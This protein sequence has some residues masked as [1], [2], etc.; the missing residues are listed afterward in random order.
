[1]ARLFFL[2]TTLAGMALSKDVKFTSGGATGCISLAHIQALSH[3]YNWLNV[4]T[5]DVTLP[6]IPQQFIDDPSE[7]IPESLYDLYFEPI[8]EISKK[9]DLLGNLDLVLKLPGPK[10]VIHKR[11]RKCPEIEKAAKDRVSAFSCDS[12][13]NP[14]ACSSCT[15]FATAALVAS[16]VSCAAKATQESP[17]CCAAAAATFAVYYTQVCLSK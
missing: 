5:S 16:C 2:L 11:G 1:M 4:S 13:P 12:A 14:G 7:C 17:F 9:Q 10:G 6:D 15:N 8:V 3:T